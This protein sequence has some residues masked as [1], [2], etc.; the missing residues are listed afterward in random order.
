VTCAASS[1]N[2]IN[3]AKAENVFWVL[4]TSLTMGNDSTL[5]GNVL[6]GSA[7]T[8]NRNGVLLGRAIPQAALTCATNCDIDATLTTVVV[9]GAG[10]DPHF[11][12]WSQD[13]YNYHGECDLVFMSVPDFASG[14]GMDLHIRTKLRE[15]MSFIDSAAVRIGNSILEVKGGVDGSY[16]LDGVENAVFPNTISGFT[17]T[18][19][20][21]TKK[22]RVFDID[23]G[24][25]E[26][27]MLKSF[28]MFMSVSIQNGGLESFGNS[29]GLMGDYKSGTILGRDGVTNF[30]GDFLGFGQEWQVK[31]DEVKL[32][33]L[34]EGVHAP[35]I[36][37]LPSPTDIKR[38]RLGSG[39]SEEAAQKA[40]ASVADMDDREWCVFDVM[41]TGDSE[42]AGAY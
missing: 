22:S 12:T 38:R 16:W 1:F 8:I 19:T 29:V 32:F 10:G 25:G 30:D 39:I 28:K 11:K 18:Y 2:L 23:I 35:E 14:I 13:R 34:T 26:H 20:K 4:G 5:V 7:I 6:A 3:G 36:C 15:Q 33:H 21:P 27:I 17:I 42:M 41:A 37:K 40:C 24:N 9:I 31:A